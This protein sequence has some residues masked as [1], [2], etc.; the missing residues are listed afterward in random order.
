[1]EKIELRNIRNCKR[2]NLER[3]ENGKDRNFGQRILNKNR[4]FQSEID[5]WL[6]IQIS[7]QKSKR[8]SKVEILINNRNFSAI[9]K[10]SQEK[11]F[12][13]RQ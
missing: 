12:L 1:M 9:N 6:K 4:N 2:S 3:I 13:N 11:S 7:S 5:I 8:W 10:K